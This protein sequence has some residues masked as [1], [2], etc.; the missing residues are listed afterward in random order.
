MKPSEAY[1]AIADIVT[2]ATKRP[3]RD[4]PVTEAE[5]GVIADKVL[6]LADSQRKEAKDVG[7][8]ASGRAQSAP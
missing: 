3:Y 6:L 4:E 5:W 1:E 8:T 7:N 2:Q